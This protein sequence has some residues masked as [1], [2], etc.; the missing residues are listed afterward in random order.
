MSS[1]SLLYSQWFIFSVFS[2]YLSKLHAFTAPKPITQIWTITF[3][4]II[5]L[6]YIII[7][8]VNIT[9]SLVVT[10]VKASASSF[11][12]HIDLYPDS[13]R[14]SVLHS[15]R[16]QAWNVWNLNLL[17]RSAHTGYDTLGKTISNTQWKT[18]AFLAAVL[19]AVVVPL[20]VCLLCLICLTVT[21]KVK[22]KRVH[23]GTTWVPLVLLVT[24]LSR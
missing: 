19:V 21:L 3:T 17:N 14:L 23:K 18:L 10:A 20:S 6:P 4:M 1:L 24:T 9:Q 13:L 12:A 5:S 2:M 22:N 16:F 7:C 11:P 8:L 15:L